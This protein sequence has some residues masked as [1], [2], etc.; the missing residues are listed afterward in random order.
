MIAPRLHAL[1]RRVLPAL[2]LMSLGMSLHPLAAMAQRP[3]FSSTTATASAPTLELAATGTVHAQPDELTAVFYAESRADT[4]AAAQ[5]Q[6]NALAAKAITTASQTDGLRVNA[7]SYFV[8][9]DDIDTRQ[10]HK[11]P[12][13]V[14]RQTIRLTA[15]E[16]KGLLPLVAQLQA[17][18]LVLTRLDWSLSTPRRAE[19]TRKAETLALQDMLQRAQ[20]AAETL[21][22]KIGTIR[23]ITLDDQ[24]F[25]RPMP[26]MMMARAASVDMATPAAP[27][28]MQD[29]TATV[30][31]TLTLQ[32][33]E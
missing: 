4:A 28:D 14:A 15:P 21:K 3:I 26:M 6:V 25:P 31:A 1:T 33:E 12:Q 2:A 24:N 9:Q 7:E 10:P 19:L 30:H 32:N 17:D 23:T 13:W 27:A 5:A 22:L 8:H 20:A 29:V 11:Q 18:N 16:G